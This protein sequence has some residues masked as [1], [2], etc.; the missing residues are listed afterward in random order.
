MPWSQ[1][2]NPMDSVI[3]SALIVSIPIVLLL[4][5]LA[6]WHMRAHYAALAGL[7]SAIA[8]AV[9]VFGMPL[10]LAGAAAGYGA[11]F[12][13]FPIGW[14]VLNAVFIYQLSVQTGT[15]EQLKTQI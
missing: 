2:Y 4:A 10:P 9:F 15:F 12:G 6:F 14:I 7:A 1:N 5:L 8:T 3:G 13:L 11:A